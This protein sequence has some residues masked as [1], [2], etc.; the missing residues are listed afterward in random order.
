MTN[1]LK[2]IINKANKIKNNYALYGMKNDDE[3]LLWCS[4]NGIA[5]SNNV[6]EKQDIEITRIIKENKINDALINSK[7]N[8]S[9]FFNVI[10]SEFKHPSPRDEYLKFHKYDKFVKIFR[11]L[12]DPEDQS[13]ALEMAKILD[14]NPKIFKQNNFIYDGYNFRDYSF[15]FF[16]IIKLKDFWIRDLKDFNVQTKNTVKFFQLLVTHLFV[17]Y[18]LPKFY[19]S[20]WFRDYKAVNRCDSNDNSVKLF[21]EIA[22]GKSLK[23]AFSEYNEGISIY[24]P[25][26]EL[27]KLEMHTL[28]KNKSNIDNFDHVVRE[29][30]FSRYTKNKAMINEV[31]KSK[32]PNVND[33]KLLAEVLSLLSKEYMFDINMLIPLFDYIKHLKRQLIEEGKLFKLK[34]QNIERLLTG[35]K[36][37]HDSGIKGKNMSWLTS[38]IPAF[39]YIKENKIHPIKEVEYKIKELLTSNQL[40]EEGRKLRH[41]VGSYADSCEKGR[42]KIFSMRVMEMG[43]TK[44]LLT[45]ETN[46]FLKVVQVRGKLNRSATEV[47]KNI[48]RK[49]S[50]E[51]G[52]I[53]NEK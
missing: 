35:M 1:K 44:N 27:S 31:L 52:V 9:S 26:P 15:A 11:L 6:T 53:Y 18:K 51:T 41:C 24:S 25:I 23:K 4:K 20:L 22:Q 36:L 48:I 46:R 37:W 47:E 30:I 16:Q 34:G 29:K 49:W 32:S 50:K 17:K 2:D 38:G 28:M 39:S 19:Y 7:K 13:V 12:K 33:D 45:I 10:S 8:H 5:I 40:S 21:I 42:A 43:M 14:K 3:F